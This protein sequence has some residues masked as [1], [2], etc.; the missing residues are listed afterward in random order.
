ML[1]RF[2][3][4]PSPIRMDTTRTSPPPRELNVAA[5]VAA[6]LVPG[7]G[8]LFVHRETARGLAIMAGLLFLV[9]TGVLV[10]GLNCVDHE[11]HRL[12][13]IAQAGC[14]PITFGL[15]LLNQGWVKGDEADLARS[16][17]FGR[18]Q[19]MGTL[20]VAL[21]GLMNIAVVLDALHHRPMTVA[22]P[23]RGGGR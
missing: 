3:D 19:E 5:G 4:L 2:P 18:P 21:A 11:E 12:W 10:G 8:H 7:G 15:D 14:G 23:A 22:A 9:L 6:W 1:E 20:F 17:S 13:F 16:T